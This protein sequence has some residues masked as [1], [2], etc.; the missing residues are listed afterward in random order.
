MIYWPEQMNLR[1]FTK[2]LQTIATKLLWFSRRSSGNPQNCWLS[3]HTP[4]QLASRVTSGRWF[5]AC[6]GHWPNTICQR[7]CEAMEYSGTGTPTFGLNW[8]DPSRMIRWKSWKFRRSK[9]V[10]KKIY[11]LAKLK[12]PSGI[13]SRA[14]CRCDRL[15]YDFANKSPADTWESLEKVGRL[16]RAMGVVGVSTWKSRYLR[17]I[18]LSRTGPN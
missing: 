14:W 17:G 18:I 7:R 2:W 6:T 8:R 12:R 13:I 3:C 4:S 1:Q 9:R 15:R 10:G 16:R 5:R 11:W